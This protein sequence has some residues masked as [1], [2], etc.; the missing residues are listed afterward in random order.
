MA[1]GGEERAS[2]LIYN[3]FLLRERWDC[4]SPCCQAVS[5]R[6]AVFTVMDLVGVLA[7]RRCVGGRLCRARSEME[8]EH[9]PRPWGWRILVEE[10]SGVSLGGGLWGEEKSPCV[11]LQAGATYAGISITT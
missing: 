11:L 6:T 9:G 3:L 4:S 10:G 5:G 2:V 7:S 8:N 1:D